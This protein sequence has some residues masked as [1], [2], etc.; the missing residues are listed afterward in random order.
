MI[1]YVKWALQKEWSADQISA[2]GKLINLPVSHEWIYRY[3][4]LD[5]AAE[6]QLYTHLRQGHK[7]DHR[8]KS[9]KR[10]PIEDSISI[11][12]RP[13]IVNTRQRVRDWEADTVLGKQGTRVLVTLAEHK[14]KIYLFN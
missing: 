6:R 9:C 3:A 10:S 4:A 11:D 14:S 1:T 12:E 5:K 8:G 7:R 2:I 13:I